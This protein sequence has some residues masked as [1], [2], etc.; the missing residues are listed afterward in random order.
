MEIR[1]TNKQNHAKLQA[2]YAKFKSTYDDE[3]RKIAR[4]V[5]EYSIA[6]L[7]DRIDRIA[8]HL[9]EHT[10]ITKWGRGSWGAGRTIEVNLSKE[11]EVFGELLGLVGAAWTFSEC[12]GKLGSEEV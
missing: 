12:T 5:S 4:S 10:I 3:A 1:G 7:K 11:P 2:V 6:D 9:R 8:L